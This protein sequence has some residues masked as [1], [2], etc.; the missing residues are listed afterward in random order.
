MKTH[1]N[2]IV[3]IKDKK[4]FKS[5]KRKVT[6]HIQGNTHKIASKFLSR[7]LADQKRMDDIFK[8]LK[9]RKNQP[10]TIADKLPFKNEKEIKTLPV[11][12]KLREFITPRPALQEMVKR[13]IQFKTKALQI[14]T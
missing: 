8:I 3:E 14:A 10:S 6:H 2:Y 4:N 1:C 7:K 9:E 13:V 5:S 12:Q 11:K